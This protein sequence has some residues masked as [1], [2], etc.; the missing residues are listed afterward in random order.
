MEFTREFLEWHKNFVLP[1]GTEALAIGELMFVAFQ[2]G[3]EAAERGARVAVAT[4]CPFCGV[5]A[6][7][8]ELLRESLAADP[9]R[10]AH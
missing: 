6:E 1:E 8:V 10:G 7:D 2:A 9:I 4:G 3:K 5:S